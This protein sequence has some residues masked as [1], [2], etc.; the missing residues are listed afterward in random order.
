MRRTNVYYTGKI[1]FWFLFS[2]V[3]KFSGCSSTFSVVNMVRYFGKFPAAQKLGRLGRK[4]VWLFRNVLLP[5]NWGNRAGNWGG[6]AEMFRMIGKSSNCW[7]KTKFV[8]A[9]RQKQRV[10]ASAGFPA[11]M[12][13]LCFIVWPLVVLSLTS[14]I[15]DRT[16]IVIDRAVFYQIMDDVW[17]QIRRKRKLC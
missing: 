8:F 12:C 11:R 17:N 10:H 14:V 3:H 4:L 7:S 9:G 15:V 16:V 1:P 5:G 2:S 13:T 6:W